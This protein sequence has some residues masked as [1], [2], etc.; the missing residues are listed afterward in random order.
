ME[1]KWLTVDE[2]VA[3]YPLT[4][5]KLETLRFK[6]KI[7]YTKSGRDTIFQREW[8]EEYFERN[9]VKPVASGRG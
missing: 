7:E 3:E 4:R 2:V 5:K 1:N 8:I 9:R 6:K